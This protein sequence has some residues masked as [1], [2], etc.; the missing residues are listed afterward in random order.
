MINFNGILTENETRI[1]FNNRAFLYGDAVFETLKI[2]NDKILFWEEHYFRLMSSMRILRMKIPMDFTLENLEEQIIQLVEQL[3]ISN[4][5]RVRLTVFRND[6][7]LYQPETNAVSYLITAKTLP[8][9]SY[10]FAK[11]AY[12][13][14]LFKEYHLPKHLLSSIKTTNK[15][16]QVL[17]SVFAK[18]NDFDDCLLINEDKNVAEAI[19]GNIFMLTGNQ[20]ATPPI[21]DG[22]LNGIMR[23]QLINEIKKMPEIELVERSISPFEVQKAD[24]V[25]VTNVISGIQPI[26]KYRKKT[27]DSK[28]AQALLDKI[29]LKEG[30]I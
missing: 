29:N 15:I 18:E 28:L 21:S 13:V 26:F 1:M 17:A 24:E 5:A 11:N 20:L 14:E 6:G 3:K 30:L 10:S 7:G 8:S 19:S 4:S 16:V 9:K 2:V 23:K 12:E 22:C 25:F 27:F